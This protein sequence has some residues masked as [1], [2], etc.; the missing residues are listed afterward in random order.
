MGLSNSSVVANWEAGNSE[1]SAATLLRLCIAY[2][3]DDVYSLLVDHDS[4]KGAVPLSVTFEERIVVLAYRKAESW[5]KKAV[6]AVL[7]LD[8][9]EVEGELDSAGHLLGWSSEAGNA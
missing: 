3:I 8:D 2:G 7:K 9:S 1:P 5:V 4:E 6:R